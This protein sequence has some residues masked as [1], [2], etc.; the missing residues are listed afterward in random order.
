MAEPLAYR[1]AELP[2]G[3]SKTYELIGAGR[4]E[5]RKVDGVT[6]IT[7]RSV[8]ALLDLDDAREAA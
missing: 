8:R 5:T 2:W 4:L 6:L 7:A 3:K 1:I